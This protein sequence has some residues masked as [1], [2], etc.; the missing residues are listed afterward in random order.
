MGGEGTQGSAPSPVRPGVVVWLTGMPSSGK[1]TLGA[2]LRDRLRSEGWAC[3]LL[4]GDA[5]RDVLVPRPGY[6]PEA[7]DAFYASLA[8]LAGLL[9]R[10]GAVVVVA[11]TAHRRAFRERARAMAPS[12]LEVFVDVDPTE[13]ARRDAK[14]LYA[15]TRAGEV[16]ALPGADLAY[17]PPEAP[18]V[19]ARG[20]LDEAAIGV[21][22][23]RIAGMAPRLC[24]SLD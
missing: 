24:A 23:E 21:I 3:C 13:C 11:A 15:A 10:D 19:V 9:A 1:S 22:A 5:V 6:S 17:E 7:R 18:D 16:S 4:D 14:G 2:R 20:G 12:F 8:G